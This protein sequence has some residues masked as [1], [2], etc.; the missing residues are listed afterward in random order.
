MDYEWVICFQL[1]PMS[2]LLH[3]I[4]DLYVKAFS[5][6]PRKVWLLALV[7]L[8]NRSGAMVVV[9]LSVYLINDLDYAPIKAGYVMAAF[10]AG[11]IAGNYIGGLLNDRFGSW[12]I[13]FYSMIGAGL[14][15]VILGQMDQF[16]SLC[17]MAFLI[18]LVADA[19]RPA[20]RAAVAIYAPPGK[21]TQS[22]GLLRMAV[23]LGLSIGPAVGGWLIHR[24]GFQLMFWGDGITFLL[25]AGV[26]YFALPP[27]ETARPL[28]TEEEKDSS[29]HPLPAPAAAPAHRQAWLLVFVVANVAIILCFFQLF[30]PLPAFLSES[31]YNEQMIGLLLTINGLLI[32][33]VE[34]PMLY[35]ME[36]RFRPIPIMVIGGLL[37]AG[38]YLLLPAGVSTGFLVLFVMM[39]FLTIGE[40]LYMPFTN[41]Y[42]SEHAPPKRRGEYLGMLS[43]SYSAAFVLAP[44]IGFGIAENHGYATA[45]FACC[46]IAAVGCLLLSRVNMIREKSTGQKAR[47]QPSLK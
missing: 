18:S 40:I 16:W 36:R 14:L 34:M 6:L 20:N 32:V 8:V 9:F 11:G 44:L 38:G 3:R 37:I 4:F 29:G 47:Q 28:V 39:I 31:G 7:L 12:H 45:T 43:A 17:L 23:N 46:A 5:G 22:F 2:A 30:G 35:V 42:V 41:T 1:R 15:N 33:A 25:A 21:L 26:F 19:F 27:D 10:G 24:Y 13:M